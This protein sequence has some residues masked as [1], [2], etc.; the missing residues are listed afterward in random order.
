MAVATKKVILAGYVGLEGSLKI[1]EENEK[2]LKLY[3]PKYFISQIKKCEL[4]LICP[5]ALDKIELVADGIL[6]E[7][8]DALLGENE[9]ENVII[10]LGE[11]QAYLS[12]WSA[13]WN[14]CEAWEKGV[15]V[16]I[17]RIPIRQETIEI[18]Q[19]FNLNPYQ[20]SSKGSYLIITGNPEE[21][22][23]KFNKIGIESKVIG[24]I[25]DK[26]ERLIIRGD[27]IRH[28]PRSKEGI[29]S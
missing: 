18:C 16:E 29:E 9:K 28:L 2:K 26:K 10:P 12:L 6:L 4:S 20:I 17:S 8:A 21:I 27:Y 25:T 1:F 19:Y 7:E 5:H 11:S 3:F 23:A 24:R 15:E 14:L 22:V 13:L